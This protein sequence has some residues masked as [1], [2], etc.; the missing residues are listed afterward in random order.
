MWIVQEIIRKYESGRDWEFDLQVLPGEEE[1]SRRI[2][3]RTL[4][5]QEEAYRSCGKGELLE[6]IRFLEK[7]GLIRKTKW[8]SYGSD[9][10]EITYALSDM[11]RFYRLEGRMPKPQLVKE[12]LDTVDNRLKQTRKLWIRRF[13][14]NELVKARKGKLPKDLK[15]Q[16]NIFVCL[17]GLDALEEPVFRR[18]FSKRYLCNSK[19]FE[20]DY[21]DSIVSAARKYHEGIDEEMSDTQVL[22]ELLIEEYAQ[23][24]AL[25]GP[26]HL[27]L[28]GKELRLE[29][30]CCGTVLN[31]ETMKLADIP[32]SQPI[33]SVITVENKANFVS[34]PYQEGTLI[35]FCHGFFSP[36]EREFL[37][38]LSKILEEQEART[39]RGVRYLHTG[40]LDYGGIRI[41]QYIRSRIFPKLQPLNMD[42]K[43]YLHYRAYGE[44]MEEQTRKK[45]E[46]LRETGLDDLIGCMRREGYT[47]EQEAFLI[48]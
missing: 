14:E 11:E 4:R 7:Q 21:Q 39:G 16:E 45:L 35:L 17:S 33:D 43:T 3:N 9:A 8:L 6:E 23:E 34:M 40:D 29:D 2:Q 15:K 48:E 13:F 22:S 44:P 10:E 37:Q 19:A 24:L 1:K 47:V 38:R 27:T 12:Y 25:K 26:L 20:Q 46:L 28:K 36:K 5:I 31:S 18:V 32:G 42:E 41:F 30:F